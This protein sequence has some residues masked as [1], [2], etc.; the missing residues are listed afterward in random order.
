MKPRYLN[1]D[2]RKRIEKMYF[3]GKEICEIASE[4][5]V[6]ES[7][8]YRELERGS[9]KVLDR[10]GRIGY[11]ADIGQMTLQNRLKHRVRRK[12]LS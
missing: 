5:S 8:I 12:D 1:Y 9:T 7:T 11:S 4:L 6:H 2:D 10:N 3:C